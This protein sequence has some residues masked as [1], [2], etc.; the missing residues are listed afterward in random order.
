MASINLKIKGK[1]KEYEKGVT[2]YDVSKDYKDDYKY[3]IL[4]G[5]IN[6]KLMPLKTEVTKDCDV[7]FYDLT[8]LLGNNVYQKGLQFLFATSVKDVLKCDVKF[9]YSLDNSIYCEI[10]SNDVIS[11]VILEKIKNKMKSY[12]E[13]GV[14]IQKIIVSRIDA[15]DYYRQVNQLDKAESLRY[16]SD[17]SISLY[18]INNTL[19]YYYYVLPNNTKSL[20]FFNVKNL[21][22]NKVVLM[23]PDFYDVSKELKYIKNDKLITAYNDNSKYL[24]DLGIKTSSDLNKIISNSDHGDIIRISEIIQNN[25]ILNMVNE[26]SKNKDIKIVLITGPSSSGKTTISK[27]LGLLFKSKGIN[28]I[29]ISLDNFFINVDERVLDEN[30][31]PEMEKISVI[32]VELFNEKITDLIN[33]KEVYMP[34]FNFK[35]GKQE[36]STKPIKMTDDSILII[37]GIHSFNEK[38]ISN[39]SNKYKYKIFLCPLTPLNIDNHNLFKSTDNRLIRR[40]V[41][42][43]IFRNTSASDT[44]KFWKN[45][46]KTEQEIIFPY[47]KD[48]DIVLNT[49]LLYEL[50]VLKTYVEALLFSVEED[51]EN[52]EEAIRLINL[53]RI[54]VAMPSDSI[55]SDSIIREFIGGSCFKD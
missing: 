33:R 9:S 16:I 34:K 44:L 54:I 32:N 47:M 25:K 42:D 8:S 2:L 20:K 11:D 17:S 40:I 18:R 7:D 1:S 29:P 23:Y 51:D 48:A 50:S 24:N 31:K 4:V 15:I 43:N 36:L 26:I 27:K 45:V 30:G 39:I 37:E 38:L 21:G 12:I 46:R 41:R 19:D 49:S 22:E 3:D 35:L 52:Y 53:F 10:L 13:E 14:E 5:S 55:P 6:N 28:P